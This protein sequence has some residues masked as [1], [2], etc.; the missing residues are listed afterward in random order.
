[1]FARGVWTIGVLGAAILAAACER[2]SSHS[3][4]AGV[5]VPAAYLTQACA[6]APGGDA[7]ATCDA[8]APKLA[9]RPGYVHTIP[10]RDGRFALKLRCVN[11]D[12]QQEFYAQAAGTELALIV[13]GAE[14]KR[15]NVHFDSSR[16]LP[17]CGYIPVE[18]VDEA[19]GVCESLASAWQSS[20]DGCTDLCP[21]E[22]GANTDICVQYTLSQ[23]TSAGDAH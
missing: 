21:D 19:I 14:I 7:L 11:P 1:M 20:P 10:Y 9:F 5:E 18:G 22:T 15:L 3:D 8:N 17:E 2:A 6:A 16:R 13:G 23:S 12:S 4:I